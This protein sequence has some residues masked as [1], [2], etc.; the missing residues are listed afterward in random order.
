MKGKEYRIKT[1]RVEII[2]PIL[3]SKFLDFK[4]SILEDFMKSLDYNRYSDIDSLIEIYQKYK[5]IPLEEM[6]AFLNEI[7][8]SPYKIFGKK[9][10]KNLDK[11]L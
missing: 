6:N 3:F 1:D 5:T 10:K 4:K 8:R 9:E 7:S 11:F 2:S